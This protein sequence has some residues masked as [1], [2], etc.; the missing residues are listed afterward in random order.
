M[1]VNTRDEICG[2]KIIFILSQLGQNGKIKVFK[3]KLLGYFPDREVGS[4]GFLRAPEKESLYPIS[5]ITISFIFNSQQ[6]QNI[7]GS[8]LYG[9]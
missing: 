9:F 2:Q 4:H 5:T 7:T 1:Q 3:L 6:L 8:V